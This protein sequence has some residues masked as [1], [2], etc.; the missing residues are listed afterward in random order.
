MRVG[1]HGD[2]H[3]PVAVHG[4][5]QNAN[6]E[7]M[8]SFLGSEDDSLVAGRPFVERGVGA[9]EEVVFSGRLAAGGFLSDHIEGRIG[10]SV[11]GG[12]NGTG[13]S[14]RSRIQGADLRLHWHDAEDDGG[15]PFVTWQSEFLSR[16]YSADTFLDTT[17]P[18]PWFPHA[19]LRDRG[20][21]S[22]VIW[23]FEPGWTLGFRWGWADGSGGGSSVDP[24]RDH[25]TRGSVALT[26]F[27]SE[28]S[29]LR[30]QVNR[31]R[32]QA[33]GDD[34]VSLWLQWEF[35]LG[36]HG[37]HADGHEEHSQHEH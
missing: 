25:R 11:S 34:E 8:P 33:L 27:P 5:V 29:K 15:F 18:D 2:E 20:F 6:G 7:T 12:A 13:A 37:E 21:T 22:Q 31:D 24:M 35:I 30:L 9:F 17:A 28:F 16:V 26:W 32:S 23:G 19:V 3:F 1:W 14:G 36:G 4:T 10:A